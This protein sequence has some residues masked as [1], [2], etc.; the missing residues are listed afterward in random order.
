[1]MIGC[2]FIIIIFISSA[3][4]WVWAIEF[5]IN[6]YRLF[7]FNRAVLLQRCS[8]RWTHILLLLLYGYLLYLWLWDIIVVWCISLLTYH[9]W[10][11]S[12][13][14]RLLLSWRS[15][16]IRLVDRQWLF[17]LLLWLNNAKTLLFHFFCIFINDIFDI[18][19]QR[20]PERFW[21]NAILLY[22]NMLLELHDMLL[23]ALTEIAINWQR[24]IILDNMLRVLRWVRTVLHYYNWSREDQI[25]H[26]LKHLY[27]LIRNFRGLLVP[28]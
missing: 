17:E 14:P 26:M 12:L 6:M 28:F 3:T 9:R 11:I 8:R 18:I 20:Y 16:S 15:L 23:S 5:L 27:L 13:D 25:Q 7:L 24:N 4:V 10:F 2:S 22:L 19:Q 21:N 1:M